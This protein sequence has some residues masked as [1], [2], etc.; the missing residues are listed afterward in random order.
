MRFLRFLEDC[1]DY[2]LKFAVDKT[3]WSVFMSL[4]VC[5]TIKRT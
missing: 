1:E 5:Y 4:E 3:P 2:L